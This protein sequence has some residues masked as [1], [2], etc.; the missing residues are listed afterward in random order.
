MR[1]KRL[2]KKERV[3][4]VHMLMNTLVIA[5]IQMVVDVLV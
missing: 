5:V 4:I 3:E 2:K 1:I